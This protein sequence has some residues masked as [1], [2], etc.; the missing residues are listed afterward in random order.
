MKLLALR[1]AA[2]LAVLVALAF[3]A[4]CST[5]GNANPEVLWLDLDGSEIKVRLVEQEPIP[6]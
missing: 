2:A 6:F 4:G 1:S 5:E 3:A